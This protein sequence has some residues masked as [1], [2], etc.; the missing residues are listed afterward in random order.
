MEQIFFT[1]DPHF[2]HRNIIKYCNRPF[3]DA[4]EMDAE[5]IRRWNAVVPTDGIVYLLGDVTMGGPERA[6]EI[7]GQLNG[8][9]YLIAGNHDKKNR[10]NARFARCFVWVKDLAKIRVQSEPI[11]LCHYPMKSWDGSYH[12]ALHFHGHSHNAKPINGDPRR[13]DVGVDAWSYAPVSLDEILSVIPELI[14][15]S[16]PRSGAPPR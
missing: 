12:D 8:T 4:D 3:A 11:V 13:V 15:E 6:I 2:G 14:R 7:L 5:L 10:R 1:S 9:K 16:L